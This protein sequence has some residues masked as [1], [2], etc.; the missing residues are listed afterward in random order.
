MVI[1]KWHKSWDRFMT[2]GVISCLDKISEKIETGEDIPYYPASENVLRFLQNDLD[3]VKY[4]I[5]GMEPY[6]SSFTE[7][8]KEIPVATGRSF[9]VANV[10][11]WQQKFKQSSLRNILKTI[12]YNETGTDKPL[13]EIREEIAAGKFSIKEP[14]A[15]FDSLEKQGV[16]FLNATLTVKPGQVD[17][18]T[19]IWSDF[20]DRLIR[21]IDGSGCTWMLWGNKAVNRVTPIARSGNFNVSCHPRLA[22]FVSENCFRKTSGID[23]TGGGCG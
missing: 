7:S 18:H 8:G 10:K 1:P 9:E 2:E 23:W 3:S 21:F 15:W 11:S 20:M 22:R 19:E 12:Y 6:P 13:T 4:V 5:V 14:P 17:S 16:M